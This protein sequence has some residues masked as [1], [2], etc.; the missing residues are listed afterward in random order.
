MIPNT[1]TS[2]LI[3]LLIILATIFLLSQGAQRLLVNLTESQ[4][5][6]QQS[7]QRGKF[8]L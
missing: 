6:S 8:S 2:Y 1:I 7:V 5:A 3:T 4:K